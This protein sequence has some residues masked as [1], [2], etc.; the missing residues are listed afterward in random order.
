MLDFV[1]YPVSAILWFWHNAFGAVLGPDNGVA[2][3]LAVIFLVFTLR[4]VLLK[5]GIGQIRTAR[6]MQKLRPRI[7]ALQHAYSDDRP[8]LVS[9]M[10]KLRKEH[11]FNPLMGCLPALLQ[12]PVFLGMCHV[13]ASF[14]RTGTGIGKLGMTPEENAHTANYVFNATD[15]QSFLGARLFGAPISA[16]ITTPESTLASFVHFGGIPTAGAIATVALPLMV[17]ASL[18]TH[19]NA[20]ASVARQD[21]V[22][23][24]SAQTAVINKI[25]LWVFP[26]GALV[27]GPVL[28]IAILLYWVSNNI[29]TYVQQRIVYA[30]LEREDAAAQRR[31][32]E[33]RRVDATARD[34]RPEAGQVPEV[35]DPPLSRTD[36]HRRSSSSPPAEKA[37]LRHQD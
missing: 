8:R 5:P 20:R 27:G 37:E 9:E 2:W 33:Q 17:I 10:Q 26:L 13:L 18:A 25:T 36:L 7:K 14:N 35:I 21:P 11:G 29:W 12:V 32:D 6:Q 24:A 3:A 30:R 23:A 1:Y 19:F 16:A 28:M 15:V 22:V 31:P 34:A 4:L